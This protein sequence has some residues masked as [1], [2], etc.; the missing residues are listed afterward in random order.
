MSDGSTAKE[1]HAGL[2]AKDRKAVPAASPADVESFAGKWRG[3]PLWSLWANGPLSRYHILHWATATEQSAAICAL[4]RFLMRVEKL[5]DGSSAADGVCSGFA[6]D[7]G[8]GVSDAAKASLP[9]LIAATRMPMYDAEPFTSALAPVLTALPDASSTCDGFLSDEAWLGDLVRYT[10]AS[11]RGVKETDFTGHRLLGVGGFGMVMVGFKK[12]T[13]KA[14]ALKR[15]NISQ[16]IEKN[17]VEAALIER[18]AVCELQSRFILDC[19]SA[20]H[21]DVHLVLALRIMPGGDVH[22]HLE[23]GG[24]FD[25]PKLQFYIASVVLGLE[26]LHGAGFV[27]RDLKDR[28]VLLDAHGQARIAD[29]GLAGDVSKGGIGGKWGTIGYHSPEQLDSKSTGK[30]PEG[31]EEHADDDDDDGDKGTYKTEPDFWTLGVCAYHWSTKFMPF[32]P[33]EEEEGETKAKDKKKIKKKVNKAI[34]KGKFDE[35]ALPSEIAGLESL[36]KGLI[37]KRADTR[38]GI[39]GGFEK[40]KAHEFFGGLDWARLAGGL[41]EAPIKPSATQMNSPPSAEMD[42]KKVSAYA[43]KKA[44][45]D[46]FSSHFANWDHTGEARAAQGY[47]DLLE[48]RALEAKK[49]EKK[50]DAT[51]L[52]VALADVHST[53]SI[54]DL[55]SKGLPAPA[56]GGGGGKGGGGTAATAGGGG[57]EGGGGGGGCCEVM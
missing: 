33:S 47:C 5:F 49:L 31:E 30:N 24:A 19:E 40:L 42:T 9:A 20:F 32:G 23:T 28:N 45:A 56:A 41:L 46:K 11:A 18:K 37:H 38:L 3:K 22:F 48:K 16:V 7:A 2:K 15:Q 10:A 27:Y 17:M 36:C 34:K 21:D 44:G 43:G 6:T 52:T 50:A 51:T 14:Y 35:S 25:G 54:A 8:A 29:F 13:G 39:D 12:D 4:A 1:I 53:E 26:V 55:L 57:G